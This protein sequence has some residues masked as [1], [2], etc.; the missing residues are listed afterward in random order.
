MHHRFEVQ[1]FDNCDKYINNH[2]PCAFVKT[3]DFLSLFNQTVKISRKNQIPSN[4][5]K[6]DWDN[7]AQNGVNLAIDATKRF[8][9]IFYEQI[10]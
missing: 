6:S 2:T 7:I 5:N 8:L 9:E 4:K 3:H 10:M 1:A